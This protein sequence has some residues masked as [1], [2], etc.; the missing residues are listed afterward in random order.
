LQGETDYDFK[1]I[2]PGTY[3]LFAAAASPT[4]DADEKPIVSRCVS[5]VI[6]LHA[7][8]DLDIALACQ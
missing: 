4:S 8:D 3:T 6:V 7:G 1:D 5:K 2:D